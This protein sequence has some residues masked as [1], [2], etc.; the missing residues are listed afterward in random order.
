MGL[1]VK[2]RPMF[3]VSNKDE[4]VESHNF[5]NCLVEL[6][7]EAKPQVAGFTFNVG[8]VHEVVV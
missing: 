7:V 5:L 2:K 4:K 3:S 1:C 6:Q 8:G